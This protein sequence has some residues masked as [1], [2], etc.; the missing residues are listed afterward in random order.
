MRR[1]HRL[2]PPKTNSNMKKLLTIFSILLSLTASAQDNT[3]RNG[4]EYYLYN[5][6]YSRCLGSNA[7]KDSPTLSTFGTNDNSDYVWVAEASTLHEGYYWLRKKDSNKYLQASNATGNTWSVWLAGSLNPAYNSY[8][9]KPVGGTAGYLISNRG[10]AINTAGNVYLGVDPEKE[11]NTYINIYY[12]KP[13][14]ER[15]TWQIVDANY[16]LDVSRLKLYTDELDAVIAQGEAIYDNA[17]YG[18]PDELAVALYNARSARETASLDAI[19][20][21]TTA[22]TALEAAISNTL[23]GKYTTWISGSSFGVNT[24]FTVAMK[25]VQFYETDALVEVQMLIRNTKGTGAII[26]LG[27]GYVRIGEN[28]ID[29][30]IPDLAD[31]TMPSALDW[32]FAFDGTNVTVYCEGNEVGSAPQTTVAAMTAVGTS[33]EWTVFGIDAI[34]G[35]TPEIVSYNFALAPG[36]YYQENN[37][38]KNTALKLVNSNIK[39]EEAIDYHILASSSAMSKSTLDLAHEDAWVIFDNLRPSD[40]IGNY[41]SS[42]KINGEAAK[43]GTNCRVAIYLQGAVVYPYTPNDIALYGYSGEMFTGD[44][45]QLKAGANSDMGEAT[46]ELNSFILKR[47]Y[48]V[49]FST[50]N[51]GS[52]YSRVYVADH[53]DKKIDVLP[54]LLRNRI[55]RAYIRKWNWVS[56]KGWCSTEGLGAINT[57]GKLLGTTWFYTWSADKSTQ[58]D[59]EYVPHKGHIYWP[60][61]SSINQ[62][63]ATAVLGYNEP[64][65]SEQHSDDCGT[66]IDAW[67]ATTHQPEFM[68]CGLRIGS[69]SPTDASWLKQ[70]IGHCD[71][72]AYRCDF[73]AFHAYWG[74]NEAPNS[75]S[76][77][78]QLNSIYQNTKRPIWLTEWNNGA[79]W[80]TE[81]WPSSYS[82]KLARQK[83]AIKSILS[84]LDNADFVERYALYNWDSYYRAAISWDSDKNN[85]WVTPC[86][87][88]YRDAHPSHAYKESMQKVPV[89]WF[90]GM[91]T[92]NQFS[93]TLKP[94]GRKFIPT[95]TNMNG[96]FTLK[97]EFQYL[98][99]ET[100]EWRFFLDNSTGRAKFDSTAERTET[101][102]LDSVH[103]PEVLMADNLTLRLHIVTLAGD[104]TSTEAVT[105]AIPDYIKNYY[106]DLVGINGVAAS[107]EEERKTIFTPLGTQSG[108]LRKGIN[109]I[110][111]ADNTTR[112]V[113]VK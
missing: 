56:K 111:N 41:L 62:T 38:S 47:G 8:E 84:V 112:K 104:E 108:T 45:Y 83:N 20:L 60:S 72:M 18:K 99:P 24:A 89:G 51:D 36:E 71:D 6:Y 1:F 29:F 34:Y 73:V 95:V 44:E 101:L 16:P 35:Y 14:N 87:E 39:L 61:W 58:T 102:R 26:F 113:L 92:N 100:G 110:R 33:A 25:Q 67:K 66:T 50:N 11:A 17:I 52:G 74:T 82:D 90:P 57:E 7:D 10:E 59:M 2:P 98:D 76:W 107:S 97:E 31:W 64:D 19:D 21:V 85:W 32:Q 37:K 42:L 3:I 75:D 4:G 80:T 55:S 43:N 77:W 70:F 69:P 78:S 88:V 106:R 5:T 68:E 30:P 96:D 94:A 12:D 63:N 49:C 48:M 53:Q 15:S 79:S 27:D 28:R 105:V 54:D 109:I 23:E 46:N 13:L 22:Q 65:H 93:F 103:M 9:W 86:G 40:V 81:S 91:K